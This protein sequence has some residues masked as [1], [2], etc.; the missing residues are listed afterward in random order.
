MENYQN[1]TLVIAPHPDDE[2]LGC[3]GTIAK[4]SY[5]GSRVSIAIVTEGYKGAPELFTEERTKKVQQEALKAHQVLGV[6]DTFFLGFPALKL[7]VT[8]AYQISSSLERMIRDT[9]AQNLYIP[10]KGDIHEDH[11]VIFDCALV[12]ARPIN[13]NPVQKIMAYET[14]SETEWGVP[15][16]DEIF[17]PNVFNNI[18]NYLQKKLEAFKSFQSQVKDFPHPRSTDV[19]EH[20]AKIRG[21][22][23]GYEAAESFKL[24]REKV[25]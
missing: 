15:E 20:Q 3:G 17:H 9:N 25:Y 12:A 2:V 18:S 8:P 21:A 7:G 5:N 1:N 16:S 4:L 11:K 23:V 24:I 6:S 10:F 14:L 13:K 22:T 19:I